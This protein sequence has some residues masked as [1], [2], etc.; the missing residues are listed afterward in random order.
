M[1]QDT[2]YV[3]GFWMAV[4]PAHLRAEGLGEG[5]AG[6]VEVEGQRGQA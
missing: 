5:R 4:W 2:L 6:S 3:R 1:D